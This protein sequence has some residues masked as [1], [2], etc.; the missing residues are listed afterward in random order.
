M[1]NRT[2]DEWTIVTNEITNCVQLSKLPPSELT[3]Q[4]AYLEK[5]MTQY[6]TKLDA[7][8]KNQPINTSVK[9]DIFK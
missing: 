4:R 7:L 2:I 9:G 6:W 3:D 1:N 8:S 5:M